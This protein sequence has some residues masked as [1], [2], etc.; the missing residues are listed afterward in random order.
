MAD[1]IVSSEDHADAVCMGMDSATH[2]GHTAL[3]REVGGDFTIL[4]QYGHRVE[5]CE[6]E[7]VYIARAILKAL[8]K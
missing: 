8:G 1:Y 7:A 4:D 2:E 5:L 3:Y 6:D